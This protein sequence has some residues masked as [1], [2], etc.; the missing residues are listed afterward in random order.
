[1]KPVRFPQD[2]LAHDHNIEWWY[3]NGHLQDKKKRKYAFMNCLFKMNPKKFGLP[4][5]KEL[6][7]KTLYFSHSIISDLEKKKFYPL[8]DYVTVISK[9]SFTKPMLFV[10]YTDP[11]LFNGYV[12]NCIHE[13]EL[14]QYHMKNAQCDLYLTAKKKPLLVGGKGYIS[15]HGR[16]TYYYSITNLDV[17]GEVF[18]NNQVREVRG[19]A[20]MDHQWSNIRFAKDKW[21]WFSVQLNTDMEILCFNY[22]PSEKEYSLAS[23]SHANN[24]Q[25][26]TRDVII[27]PLAQNW[28]STKTKAE[29]P[30]AWSIHIPEKKIYLQAEPYIQNQEMVYGVINYWEGPM[31]IT[32]TVRGKRVHGDGFLELVGRPAKH[33]DIAMI[34]EVLSKTKARFR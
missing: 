14:F 23:I 1:M 18:V 16:D 4:Y 5:V 7:F 10:D 29:Y 3:W 32:G 26:H 34:K 6:P 2:E 15:M 21:T 27:K 22:G 30:I 24:T 28:K 9:E 19:K 13:Q 11:F 12:H 8:M 33:P 31:K 25:S 20:W 17:H